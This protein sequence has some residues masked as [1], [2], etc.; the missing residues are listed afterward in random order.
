MTTPNPSQPVGSGAWLADLQQRSAKLQEDINNAAVTLTSSDEA[1]TVTVGPNGALQNLSLGHRAAGHSTTQLGTLI[2][3]TVRAA[4]RKS[5]ERVS[6]AFVPFGNP[7]LTEQ[8]KKFITYEP[9]AD[10]AETVAADEV[11]NEDKFVPADLTEQPPAPEPPTTQPATPAAQPPARGR[12][13]RPTQNDHD[14]DL[15]PW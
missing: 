13:G 5:A 7:E 14:D 15:E 11:P 12:R 8:T 2:M 10:E 1:V 4:Q 3:N 6:E 9:P